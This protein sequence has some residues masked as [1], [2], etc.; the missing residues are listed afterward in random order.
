MLNPQMELIMVRAIIGRYA[1]RSLQTCLEWFLGILCVL[2][3]A[4]LLRGKILETVVVPAVERLKLGREEE[5]V[6]ACQALGQLS[7]E[8][9]RSAIPDLV[10]ATTDESPI[11]RREAVDALKRLGLRSDVVLSALVDA[12]EDQDAV[13]R[14]EA[15]R[16]LGMLGTDAGA[17]AAALMGTLAD[18]S[19][20]VRAAATIALAMVAPRSKQAVAALAL[21]LADDDKHVREAVR[22]AL[23]S[24]GCRDTSSNGFPGCVQS[25]PAQ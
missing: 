18:R 21:S 25:H 3:V 1:P 11:V 23:S 24:M 5:R 13:V 14:T 17:A 22:F 15:A 2:A 6:S 9:A 8:E 7:V 4:Y 20:E 10:Y 19:P 12:L 16:A